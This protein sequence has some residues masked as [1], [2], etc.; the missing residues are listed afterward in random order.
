[1]NP[2]TRETPSTPT[3]AQPEPTEALKTHPCAFKDCD[4]LAGWRPVLHLRSEKRGVVYKLAV[5]IAFCAKHRQFARVGQFFSLAE[6]DRMRG[7]FKANGRRPP[8]KVLTRL[9]W[10][11][12]EGGE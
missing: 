1:M 6:W 4:R 8:K 9:V 5:G 2:E 10:V 11:A 3:N 12:V 7:A